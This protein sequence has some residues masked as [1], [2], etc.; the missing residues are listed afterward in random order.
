MA[1]I[2]IADGEIAY[3]RVATP[4]V[5]AIMSQEAYTKHGANRPDDCVLLIDEDLVE[6][7]EALEKDRTVYGIP[8]TRL[9]EELGRRLVANI[10]MLGFIAGT[11]QVVDVE[12][13]R[14]AVAASVPAGTEELNLRAFE[15]G[16]EHADKTLSNA[17]K[18]S[19]SVTRQLQRFVLARFDNFL[20]A[21]PFMSY[22]SGE[23]PD[24][25]LDLF[26]REVVYTDHARYQYQ[27][28]VSY[29]DDEDKRRVC[30]LVGEVTGFSFCK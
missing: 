7:D 1:E 5:A 13:M 8:A 18:E 25:E 15:A 14:Q 9:A 16:R 27:V 28:L 12:A 22:L 2:I 20:D 17:E 6:L 3:P 26:R 30:R 24:I 4:A 23:I 19:A 21:E 10:V 11:T 29:R